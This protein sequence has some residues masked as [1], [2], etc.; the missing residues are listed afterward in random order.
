MSP[1]GRILHESDKPVKMICGPYGSGKSCACAI[2]VLSYACAQAAAPDGIRYTRIGVIRSTYN[3]L[4]TTTRKSLL[5]VFPSS[6]GSITGGGIS[7]RGLYTIPLPD[8]TVAQVE[9]NFIALAAVEDCEK[10]KS[11]NWTFAWINE[12]TGVVPEVFSVVQQRVGR[13]P[14][15]DMGG[16][17]WGGVLLDFNMPAAGTWLHTLMQNPPDN[18]LCVKQPPAAFCHVDEHGHTYYE[19]NDA[20]EN[21]RNLGAYEEGDPTEF[22][23]EEDY[24][25]YLHEK[26]KRYY[27]NQIESLQ[28][29]GRDDVIKNQYCMIDIPIVEGKP[30]YSNFNYDRHVAYEVIQPLQFTGIVIGMDQSGIHPAAVILQL[31]NQRWCVLDELYAEG[32]GLEDF[33]YGILLPILRDKY[34][35][36]PVTAALDPSNTKDSWT[37]V[38]PKQRLEDIGIPAVTELTNSPKIRIQMV[39]HMLNLNTGGLLISPSCKMLIRGFQSEYRYRRLRAS[40]TVGAVYTPQPEKNEYSHPHD[41]LQYACLLIQKGT[42]VDERADQ[43]ARSLSEKRHRMGRVM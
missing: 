8:K 9:L 15:Q 30:V 43:I 34:S 31:Q 23:T 29:L 19:V 5:E 41:A 24:N 28:R 42:E 36:C 4:L 40:G 22:D 21:L 3:E 39:E 27:R 18:Y 16:V 1:T 14:S 2:D 11:V 13:F 12:A 33:L 17:S 7:P 35:T 25:A 10:L 26:G 6:C 32:E 37:A 38:T 20:A